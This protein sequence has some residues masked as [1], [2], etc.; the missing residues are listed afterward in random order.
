MA[1]EALYICD[2]V[3]FNVSITHA[4][5]PCMLL[6][7]QRNEQV[8]NQKTN[9]LDQQNYKV[10]IHPEPKILKQLNFEDFLFVAFQMSHSLFFC[11]IFFYLD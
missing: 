1:Y 3:V 9:K 7:K 10:L 8:T 4:S 5:L 6:K 2:I 11:F